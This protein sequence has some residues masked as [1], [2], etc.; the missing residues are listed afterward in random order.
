[1][2]L[3]SLF[4]SA[5]EMVSSTATKTT[6]KPEA[7][8]TTMKNHSRKKYSILLNCTRNPSQTLCVTAVH[9]IARNQNSINLMAIPYTTAANMLEMAT[10]IIR[11]PSNN[12]VKVFVCVYAQRKMARERVTKEHFCNAFNDNCE[13]LN[14]NWMSMDDEWK[15]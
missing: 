9:H 12:T 15:R 6:A 10:V 11:T 4:Q 3:S 8:T 5:G 14:A 2:A 13:E 7:A 1:M